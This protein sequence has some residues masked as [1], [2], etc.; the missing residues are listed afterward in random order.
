M[1]KPMK[2]AYAAPSS[3]VME[4]RFRGMLCDSFPE[5]ASQG[6]MNVLYGEETI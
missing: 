5:S 4:M 6:N 3:E 2:K 1:M